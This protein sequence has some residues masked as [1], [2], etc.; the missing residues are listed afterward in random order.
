MASGT[1]FERIRT[2]DVRVWAAIGGALMLIVGVMWV[3]PTTPESNS[4]RFETE[5]RGFSGA[6]PI[7][8]DNTVQGALVDGSDVDFYRINPLPNA[9]QLNVHLANGS[10]KLIPAIRIFDGMNNLVIESGDEYVRSPGIDADCQFL[11]QP[12][13]TYYV[14]V[15]SQRT[16]SGPYALTVTARQP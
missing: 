6:R 12:N 5:R 16:T 8:I 2:M 14:Q 7:T 10:G 1:L 13:V 11:A 3:V 15:S 4:F 9:A